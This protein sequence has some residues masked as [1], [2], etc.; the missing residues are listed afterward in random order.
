M[1]VGD[2]VKCV[3]QPRSSG[4]DSKRQCVL[5]MEHIIE[6]KWGIYIKDRDDNSGVVLFPHLGYTHTLAW[7]ALEVINEMD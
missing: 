5:P 4:Y 7:T 6:G 3:W 2:L 1:Q